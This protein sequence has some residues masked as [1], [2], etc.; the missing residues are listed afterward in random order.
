MSSR[1]KKK[2]RSGHKPVAAPPKKRFP[3]LWVSL[4]IVVAVAA[5]FLVASNLSDGDESSF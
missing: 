5:V 1:E 2:R 4:I 3:A